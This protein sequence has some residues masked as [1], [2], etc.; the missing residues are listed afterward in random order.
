MPG[1]RKGP[2]PPYGTAI[3][4]AIANGDAAELKVHIG[5]IEMS[6]AELA[7][8]D[9]QALTEMISKKLSK[10]ELRKLQKA[11]EKLRDALG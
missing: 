9:P 11:L 8:S 1:K 3:R 5:T 7:S 2:L 6:V 10:A 4:D